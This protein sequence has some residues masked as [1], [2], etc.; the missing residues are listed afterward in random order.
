MRLQP[1]ISKIKTADVMDIETSVSA[2]VR[3][4]ASC[5]VN[6]DGTPMSPEEATAIIRDQTWEETI[7]LRDDFLAALSRVMTSRK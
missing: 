6:D 1:N 5:A 2:A 4:M 7:A 3:M